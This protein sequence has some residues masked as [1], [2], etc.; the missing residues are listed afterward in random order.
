M[1]IHVV[2]NLIASIYNFFAVSWL[3]A[4]IVTTIYSMTGYYYLRVASITYGNYVSKEGEEKIGNIMKTTIIIY[5]VYYLLNM[6]ISVAIP[7][8]FSSEELHSQYSFLGS[9]VIAFSMYI[10][11]Y[12]KTKVLLTSQAKNLSLKIET[13]KRKGTLR[14]IM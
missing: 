9:G 8:M 5:V 1:L 10:Y 11:F 4:I 14:T 7:N 13:P 2:Y 12:N 3:D 6:I